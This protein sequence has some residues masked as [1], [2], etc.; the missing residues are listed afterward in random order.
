M[1]K[2]TKK[3]VKEVI[4]K[5]LFVDGYKIKAIK[6]VTPEEQVESDIEF[7]AILVNEN[8]LVMKVIKFTFDS[9]LETRL[10]CLA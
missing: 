3:E 2:W 4:E 1:K 9:F 5:E 10:M 6:I 7:E 8:L